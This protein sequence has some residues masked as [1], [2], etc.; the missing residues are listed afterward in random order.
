MNRVALVSATSLRRALKV[1]RSALHEI[2]FH[3]AAAAVPLMRQRELFQ[4]QAFSSRR[5]RRGNR[6]TLVADAQP[7]TSAPAPARRLEEAWVAVTDDAS[8]QTV[9]VRH[10]FMIPHR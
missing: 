6:G 1:N 2:S 4:K 8:N 9:R 5:G 7:S 10:L 3:Q